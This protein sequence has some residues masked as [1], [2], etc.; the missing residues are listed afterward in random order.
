M[1]RAITNHQGSENP[2]QAT[3]FLWSEFDT[4]PQMIRDLINFG[5]VSVGTGY[6][7][8]QLQAGI[9]VEFVARQAVRRWRAYARQRALASYGPEHPSAGV[10]A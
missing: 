7:Y 9:D 4:L 5:P 2:R 1:A 6:V 8:A 10:T 3:H